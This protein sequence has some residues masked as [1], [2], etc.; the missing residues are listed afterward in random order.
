M[1]TIKDMNKRLQ[2]RKYAINNEWGKFCLFYTCEQFSPFTKHC[3]WTEEIVYAFSLLFEFL[4]L[5][6][7]SAANR[8]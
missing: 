6:V 4:Y 2:I 8:K 5:C 1:S 7:R 3:I